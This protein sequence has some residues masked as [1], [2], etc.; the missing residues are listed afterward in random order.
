LRYLIRP[1]PYSDE[2]LEFYM[3]RVA[4]QNGYSDFSTFIKSLKSSVTNSFTGRF[5]SFLPQDI[6]SANLHHAQ[7]SSRRRI[8]MLR[9][10]AELTGCSLS[11]LLDICLARGAVTFSKKRVS[12]YRQGVNIPLEELRP[13]DEVPVCPLCIKESGF[14]RQLWHFRSYTSCH[15]HDIVLKQHCRC[16]ASLNMF[17]Q[18]F[19]DGCN[20]CGASLLEQVASASEAQL[21]LSAWLAGEAIEYLPDVGLSHRWGLIHWFR[22]YI[23]PADCKAADSI[24][25][26]FKAWPSILFEKLK[27]DYAKAIELAVLP[28]DEMTFQ[29][30]F[31]QLLPVSCRLPGS[32]LSDNIVLRNIVRFLSDEVIDKGSPL[33]DLAVNSIEAAILLNTSTGQIASLY[34]QGILQTKHQLKASQIATM[35]SPIFRLSDVLC[36]WLT[37]YQSETSNRRYLV[38]K[39]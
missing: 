28:T 26:Y 33:G 14:G 12:L 9:Q 11:E 5:E 27:S 17:E 15:Q 23:A 36:S 3:L 30:V 22:L 21:I 37:S 38:S 19:S 32:A 34:D 20:Q 35:I 6:A 10:F 25:S 16:G 31:G 7:I 8:D 18:T 13:L 2:S 24:L 4:T 29:D 1:K 39:W